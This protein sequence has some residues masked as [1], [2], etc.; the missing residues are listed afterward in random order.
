MHCL[1][2]YSYASIQ[3]VHIAPAIIQASASCLVPYNQKVVTFLAIV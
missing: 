3:V 1:P 2:K